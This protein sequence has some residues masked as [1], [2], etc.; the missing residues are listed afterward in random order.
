MKVSDES[1][2]S[3]VSD[4][5]MF[6]GRV[7]T[8]RWEN[9][10]G[11]W[12]RPRIF[13]PGCAGLLMGDSPAGHGPRVKHWS[14]PKGKRKCFCG[15][16]PEKKSFRARAPLGRGTFRGPGESTGIAM[17]TGLG[18]FRSGPR[19][20]M[21]PVFLRMRR[22][23]WTKPGKKNIPAAACF[24]FHRGPTFEILATDVFS[25]VRGENGADRVAVGGLPAR[26]R[27][28]E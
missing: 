14:G 11:R 17:Y 24:G 21:N 25:F 27:C 9:G 12:R 16:I 18:V 2:P 10:S 7:V 23:P 22:Y 15:M 1:R 13:H 28:P 6:P 26:V 5:E 19:R 4:K 8:K 3:A 20:L